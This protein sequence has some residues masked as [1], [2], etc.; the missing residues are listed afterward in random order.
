AACD[1]IGKRVRIE[2]IGSEQTEGTA[3]GL[4]S[5]GA[6]RLRAKNGKVLEIRA[7]DVIHLR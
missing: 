5:D 1:T 6:L 4:A 3:E 2:L 7:G